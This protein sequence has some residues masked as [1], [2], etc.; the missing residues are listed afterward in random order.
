MKTATGEQ[1]IDSEEEGTLVVSTRIS[2]LSLLILAKT[3]LTR[4]KGGMA[5]TKP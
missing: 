4:A 3:L 2:A 5:K 1:R